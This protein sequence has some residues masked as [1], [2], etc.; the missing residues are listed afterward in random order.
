M[1]QHEGEKSPQTH[2]TQNW[3]L[4]K[5]NHL[6]RKNMSSG[7]RLGLLRLDPKM[8]K[9]LASEEERQK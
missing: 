6:Y 5:A 1:N 3:N 7:A 2:I 8:M 9:L 4:R